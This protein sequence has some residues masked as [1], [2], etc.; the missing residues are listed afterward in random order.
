MKALTISNVPETNIVCNFKAQYSL[1]FLI[2]AQF[3]QVAIPS[4]RNR[5]WL[6]EL[7][8]GTQLH[9]QPPHRRKRRHFLFSPPTQ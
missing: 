7:L 9:I 4:E 1:F 2:K 3:F 6:A 8:R 5:M